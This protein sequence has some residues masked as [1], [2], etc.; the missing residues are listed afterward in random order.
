MHLREGLD[1]W[2][3]LSL[4]LGLLNWD[5]KS[6][7]HSVHVRSSPFIGHECEVA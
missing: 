4:R 7:N 6:T 1:N 5:T 2:Q 3:E